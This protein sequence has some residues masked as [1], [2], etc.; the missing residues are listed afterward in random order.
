MALPA[1]DFQEYFTQ[2]AGGPSPTPSKEY[3]LTGDAVAVSTAPTNQNTGVVGPSP[4]Q[5]TPSAPTTAPKPIFSGGG[6]PAGS[7]YNF[8]DLFSPVTKDLQKQQQALGSAKSSFETA[9]GP[10]RTY[11]GIGAQGTLSSALS[12]TGDLGTDKAKIDEG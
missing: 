1:Q 9:A 2:I 6:A 5:T 7:V 4:A 3:D 10:S 8:G 12:P 11:E